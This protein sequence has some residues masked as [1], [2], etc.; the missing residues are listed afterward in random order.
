M[1][2]I[3]NPPAAAGELAKIILLQSQ[4][5]QKAVHC[6]KNKKTE[7]CWPTASRSTDWRMKLTSFAKRHY[8]F[9]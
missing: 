1:Y 9:V 8:D 4:E 7:K 2:R 5:L 3:S 6:C